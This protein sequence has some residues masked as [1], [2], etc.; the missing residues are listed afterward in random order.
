MFEWKIMQTDPNP[1]NFLYDINKKRLNLI[2]FGSGRFFDDK[3]LNGYMHIIHGAFIKNRDQ[4]LHYSREVGFLTGE[5]NK[6]MLN[7]HYCGTLAMA[8]PFQVTPN[9]LYDFGQQ[10]ILA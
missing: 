10:T 4:V 5:E 7:A 8:E 3:F 9:G 2:D 6:E 1:A